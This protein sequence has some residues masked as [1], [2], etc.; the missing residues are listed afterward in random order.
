MQKSKVIAQWQAN[1]NLRNLVL[2]A[3]AFQFEQF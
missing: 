1:K 2:A 3:A